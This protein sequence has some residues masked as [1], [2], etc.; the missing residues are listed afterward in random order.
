MQNY[1]NNLTSYATALE[2]TVECKTKEEY[3]RLVDFYLWV[4]RIE[5]ERRR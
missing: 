3:I 4:D 2:I 5:E 1:K